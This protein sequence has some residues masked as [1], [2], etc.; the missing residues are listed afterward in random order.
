ML[1]SW[2]Q[3]YLWIIRHSQQGRLCPF[4]ALLSALTLLLQLHT[5][6]PFS[7]QNNV[8]W[9]TLTTKFSS[10]SKNN[11]KKWNALTINSSF[12]SPLSL[13]L[14]QLPYFIYF[15]INWK[16][17]KSVCEREEKQRERGLCARLSTYTHENTSTLYMYFNISWIEDI[18]NFSIRIY[19]D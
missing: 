13:L 9:G 8:N 2:G 12:C 5:P 4:S 17:G 16:K 14:S 19:L 7:F 15:L 18:W 3:K 6:K 1:K 10:T 11:E